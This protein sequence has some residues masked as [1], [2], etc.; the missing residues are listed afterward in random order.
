MNVP[1]FGI[2]YLISGTACVLWS[3][4]KV[5]A[6][7]IQT[8]SALFFVI[9]A[10]DGCIEKWTDLKRFGFEGPMLLISVGFLCAYTML[11]LNLM[12]RVGI[13]KRSTAVVSSF[14]PIVYALSVGFALALR[15]V[16]ADENPPLTVYVFLVLIFAI[17]VPAFAFGTSQATKVLGLRILPHANR[18]EYFS[19]LRTPLFALGLPLLATLI[20][21]AFTGDDW[22][23]FGT[24]A[25][26]T[27]VVASLFA[28]ARVNGDL[29]IRTMDVANEK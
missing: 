18:L 26:M 24:N 12:E 5:E 10:M 4:R 20:I 3:F 21:Q 16:K 11:D 9:A 23:L 8:L 17:H 2:T 25:V 27:I 15:D 7:L 22:R 14:L 13:K 6:R 19:G 28:V 1:L 29:V